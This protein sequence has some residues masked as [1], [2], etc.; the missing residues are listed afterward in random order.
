MDGPFMTVND[1]DRCRLGH[2][3]TCEETVAFG[4]ACVRFDLETTLE[5]AATIP[6]AATP[7]WLVTMNSTV[8]LKDL[9]TGERKTCRL[10]YPEDREFLRNS[11]GI[12]QRL[13]LCLL[14][15]CVGDIVEVQERNQV[16][17]FRIESLPYQPEAAGDSHL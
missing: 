13:G 7:R 9:A 17:R 2:L 5:E 3:L 15:R 8:V 1:R 12:L 10:A 4:S 16:R 6:A 11:V 14:G